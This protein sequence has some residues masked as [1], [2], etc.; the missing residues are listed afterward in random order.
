MTNYWG[1]KRRDP[2]MR[3]YRYYK[4]N[5]FWGYIS[6]LKRMFKG[7]ETLIELGCGPDSPTQHLDKDIDKIGVDIHEPW[8]IESKK[9]RLFNKYV[10][11]DIR[12][13]FDNPFPFPDCFMILDVIEHLQKEEGIKLLENAEKT[14]KKAVIVSTPNG[15]MEQKP[16][17]WDPY[18][19]HKSGWT[20]DD[21]E[22]RG[23]KVIGIN[24]WK[25]L[26]K[27]GGYMRYT[28]EILCFA[29]SEMS[30]LFVRNN[31]NH[32]FDILAVKRI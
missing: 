14:T 21:F 18:S 31:P 12:T 17:K 32:A 28:P 19:E 26:R 11:A 8:L 16:A 24:G 23:Y 22:E 27:E 9:R 29:I 10:L 20:K 1:F 30:Q 15:F 25:K 6:E 3:L 2:I 13:I 4:R 7:C 5:I